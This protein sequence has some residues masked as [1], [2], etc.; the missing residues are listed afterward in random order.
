MI[1]RA[2]A[3]RLV[4]SALWFVLVTITFLVLDL[5]T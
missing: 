1:L 4:L 3:R 5:Y 2:F